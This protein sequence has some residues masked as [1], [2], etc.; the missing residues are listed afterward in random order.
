MEAQAHMKAEIGKEREQEIAKIRDQFFDVF[1]RANKNDP[2]P[3]D[4]EKLKK[5]LR[6]HADL[7]LWRD[8]SGLA[9]AAE[10]MLLSHD[11]IHGGLRHVWSHRLEEMRKELGW[12]DAPQMEQLMISHAAICWLRLNML[13][14][15]AASILNQSVTLPQ[16]MFWER[17]L[18][19]AQRRF[20]RALESLARLRMM[21]AATALIESR[22]ERQAGNVRQLKAVG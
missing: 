7:N 2:R 4:V 21:T 14:I 15:F 10:L 12:K 11:S 5:M 20:T 17:R 22:I 19:L 8:V 3:A 18:E 13:E 9:K 16:G 1:K 6:E